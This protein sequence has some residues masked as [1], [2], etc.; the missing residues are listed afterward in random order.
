VAHAIQYVFQVDDPTYVPPD[1]A[2]LARD[3]DQE[4]TALQTTQG[5]TVAEAEARIEA[6]VARFGELAWGLREARNVA[7]DSPATTPT[8]TATIAA[9]ATATAEPTLT[10]SS[11]PT[12]TPTPTPTPMQEVAS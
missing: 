11:T 5:I 3:L 7:A 2:A 8:P 9:T 6:V 12:S 1:V 4:L 10:P